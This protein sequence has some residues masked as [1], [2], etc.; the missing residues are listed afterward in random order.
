MDSRTFRVFLLTLYATGMRTGEALTLL[1][2]DVD[3]NRSAI[4]IRGALVTGSM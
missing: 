3:V 1:R 2:E 4:T